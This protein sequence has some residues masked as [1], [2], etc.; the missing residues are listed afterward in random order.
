MPGGSSSLRLGVGYRTLQPILPFR[1]YYASFYDVLYSDGNANPRLLA[2]YVKE[3][4]VERSKEWLHG[5]KF[6]R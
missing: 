6:T 3:E 2:F 4:P 5:V 1:Y